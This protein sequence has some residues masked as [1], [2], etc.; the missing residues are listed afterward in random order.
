MQGAKSLTW[1]HPLSHTGTGSFA[2]KFRAP[3]GY[4]DTWEM[5]LKLLLHSQG[6]HDQDAAKGAQRL[7]GWGTNRWCIGCGP[8]MGLLQADPRLPS[9][10]KT[11]GVCPL[12]W[13][14]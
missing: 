10:T 8:P 3:L 6:K 5:L 14:P 9:Q 1:A 4:L 2:F 7:E 11:Y 13:H 12:S